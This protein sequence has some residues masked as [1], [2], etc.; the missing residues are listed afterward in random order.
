[1][2]NEEMF[3]KMLHMQNDLNSM[4]NSNWRE[5]EREWTTAIW[6]ECAELMGSVPWKWWKKQIYD[7]QN[8][9]IE[10]V[11]IWHFIMSYGL[12][13]DEVSLII[14]TQLYEDA[15][16]DYEINKTKSLDFVMIRTAIEE[17]AKRSLEKSFIFALESFYYLMRYVKMDI[18]E[19][20]SMYISKQIL[21]KFRQD[22]GYRLGTYKKIWN[23]K[24]DNVYLH[25]LLIEIPVD[26]L[27]TE[28][29]AKLQDLYKLHCL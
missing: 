21:N 7:P 22:Y 1:M 25:D 5:L 20:Y 27:E 16:E 24:E 4:I 28:L 18:T 26:N 9:K 14:F 17:L 10:I 3:Q 29:Y 6:V 11:D 8:V 13:E 19:L 2:T 23:G 15:F 12:Q